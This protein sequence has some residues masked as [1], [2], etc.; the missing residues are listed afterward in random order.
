M[1]V[2]AVLIDG[3][4]FVKRFRAIEPHNAYNGKRAAELAPSIKA[5][6]EAPGMGS[7]QSIVRAPFTPLFQC[8]QIHG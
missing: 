5:S 4:Y 8:R 1:V 2:A 3:A 6:P 7:A